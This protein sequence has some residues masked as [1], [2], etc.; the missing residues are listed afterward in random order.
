MRIMKFAKALANRLGRAWIRRINRNQAANQPFRRHNERGI[1]YSFV[2]RQIAR[3]CPK[4][5][6]DV[7]TGTTALPP[8]FRICGAVVTASDNVKDYWPKGMFNPHWH[9]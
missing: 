8:L 9:V 1:E 7:G 6:L 4:S 5:I 2:F 3:L